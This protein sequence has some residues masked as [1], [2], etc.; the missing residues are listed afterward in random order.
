MLER[1]LCFSPMNFSLINTKLMTT[2][3]VYLISVTPTIPHYC[4]I[5][6]IIT[7]IIMIY[8]QLNVT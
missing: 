4:I 5:I 8:E 2:I 7:K 1:N 6:I 3:H